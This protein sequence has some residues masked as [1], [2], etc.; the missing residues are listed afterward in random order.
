MIIIDLEG[1]ILFGG[2]EKEEKEEKEEELHLK[3][4][5]PSDRK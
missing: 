3:R 1:L 4:E 5:E 2:G